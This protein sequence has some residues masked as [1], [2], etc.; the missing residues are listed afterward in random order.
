MSDEKSRK[1]ELD[2]F[3]DIG[4]LV[5][6]KKEVKPRRNISFD[7][8][9]VNVDLPEKQTAPN[10]KS[11]TVT[12]TK[13]NFLDYYELQVSAYFKFDVF[14]EYEQTEFNYEL[15]LKDEYYDRL[16]AEMRSF[17]TIKAKY[18]YAEYEAKVTVDPDAETYTL[19]PTDELIWTGENSTKGIKSFYLTFTVAYEDTDTVR[20]P[21]DIQILNA[22]GTLFLAKD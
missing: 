10:G 18:S 3:W 1:D 12:I 17:P 22:A 14:G 19:T 15:V 5:P 20:Y 7:T 6:L 11:N 4:S 9:T 8:N 21:M 13:D 2:S 16:P